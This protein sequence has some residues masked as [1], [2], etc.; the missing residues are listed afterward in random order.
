MRSDAMWLSVA[1]G[2]DA[3]VAAAI[4]A[5]EPCDPSAEDDWPSDDAGAGRGDTAERLL[6]RFM[7]LCENPRTSERMLNLVKGSLS[8]EGSGRRF[9]V[10]FNSLVLSPV[11]RLGGLKTSALRGELVASQL[12]GLAMMRYVIKVE[13]MCSVDRAVVVE[14]MAPAVR[15]ALRG[16]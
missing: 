8:H 4:A 13:P 3:Q 2:A 15:A 10:V 6:H 1:L 11:M 5:D 9:Y 14:M 12:V 7:G 16:E